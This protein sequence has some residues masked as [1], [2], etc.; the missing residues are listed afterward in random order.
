MMR[1]VALPPEPP[2]I[3]NTAQGDLPHILLVLDQLAKVHA[4]MQYLQPC[5]KKRSRAA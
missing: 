4:N 5:A 2:G 3:T 1:I